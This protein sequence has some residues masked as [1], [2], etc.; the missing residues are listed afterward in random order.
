LDRN[1]FD[2]DA[3]NIEGLKGTSGSKFL[4]F[5]QL[6]VAPRNHYPNHIRIRGGSADIPKKLLLREPFRSFTKALLSYLYGWE[7][8]SAFLIQLSAFRYLEAALLELNSCTCPTTTT[9]E[10][11]NRACTLLAMEGFSDITVYNIGKQLQIIYGHMVDLGLVA[12]P[13]SWTTSISTPQSNLS[14]V[15]KQF[16]QTRHKRLP[17]PLALNALASIFNSTTN[18]SSEVFASSLCALM[19]CS[20]D[21]SVEALYAPKDIFISD[22]IDPKTGEVGAGLRW[23]PAKG[24][25]PMVKTVIP[26]MRDIAVRAVDNLLRLSEPARKLA[27]WYEKNPCKIYL[28]PHLEHLRNKVRINQY[29]THAILFGEKE[30][31][32]TRSDFTRSRIWLDANNVPRVSARLGPEQGTTTAFAD[33]ENSVLARLPHGFPVMDSD[34][35]MRYSEALCLARVSEFDT[36]AGSPMQCCFDRINYNT[37]QRLLKSQRTTKSIFERLGYQDEDG[38]FLSLTSN[39]LRHYLNTLVRQSGTLTEEDIAE[40]SG[41]RSV[42]QNATYNHESDRDVIAKLRE[43]VGNPI[44]AVGP[45][46]NI[47]NRVFIKRDEFAN[48]KVITSHT[49]EIGYCIHDYAQSPC[50]VHQDCIN[51]NEQI[52]V[53]GDTRAEHNLRKSKVEL[54]QLQVQ[55]KAAFSAEVL[56]AAEWFSYQSKTLERVNQLIAIIDDP[57]VP[58]GSVIQISGVVPPSRLAMADEKRHLLI[59]PVSKLIS[60]LDEVHSLLKKMDQKK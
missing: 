31:N 3:W 26:S 25:A 17:S 19:L 13:D 2:D 11:L 39:M 43:A 12:I 58:Q 4:Y 53:K 56:G 49:T 23:F 24:A 30:E 15:G 27:K 59:Q 34:T 22:W 32:P 60:S 7:Q 1:C 38:K 33:L 45:L 41:R 5:T 52:C 51:C 44:L 16:D 36:R 10:V 57:D 37:F 42:R 14:R 50:Q 47:D 40:W 35:G 29:E 21:R 18:N 54:T 46:A 9:P 55:A 48:I 8:S 20:P 28:P 6:G